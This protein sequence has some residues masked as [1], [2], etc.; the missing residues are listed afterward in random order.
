MNEFF[1]YHQDIIKQKIKNINNSIHCSFEFFPPKNTSLETKLWLTIDKLSILKPKFF[2]V[3]YGANSG[4]RK[5]TYD[6]VKQINKKTGIITA[7]HLTCINST[8]SKLKE[9]AKHYWNN[10]I[11]NIIALRGDTKEKNYKHTMYA[12]DLVRLLKRIANF[13]ISVAAYPELHPESKNIKLDMINLKKKIDAGANRAITQFFFNV[14]HY[15]YFRENCIKYGIT[16]E[17]IPGIL[18]ISDFKQLKRFLSMTNVQIPKWMFEIFSGLDDNDRFTQ[19]VIGCT[20]AIDMIQKLSSEGV[21][22]FHFYTL[23]QSD[24]SYSVCHI[25][26]LSCGLSCF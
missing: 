17:I 2:S 11:K 10:G 21:K 4:E 23:N 8:P 20:I 16:A 15:L 7:A 9:I 18:P 1:Q 19:K 24:I 12:V 13:D 14:D 26:G 25:L 22:N 6:I 3:T 5:K